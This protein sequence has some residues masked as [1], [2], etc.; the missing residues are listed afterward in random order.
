MEFWEFMFVPTI[1]FMVIVAPIWIGLHYKSVNRST[2]SLNVEDRENVEQILI[3]VDRLTERIKA[4]ESI[5]DA[6]HEDWREQDS[7]GNARSNS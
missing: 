7:A 4:L 2:R 5:L 1:L 3:T 6:E